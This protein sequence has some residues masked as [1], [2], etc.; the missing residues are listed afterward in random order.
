MAGQSITG[1]HSYSITWTP[2]GIV[3]DVDGTPTMV[4]SASTIGTATYNTFFAHPFSVILDLTV[5][6]D[7]SPT[8]NA[9]TVFPA[10][11]LVSNITVTQT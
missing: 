1:W 3:W 6:G 11:M 5:G 4:I 7:N 8:P 2:S 10:K 9:G